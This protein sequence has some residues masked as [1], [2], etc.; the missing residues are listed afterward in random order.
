[1]RCSISQLCGAPPS[2]R[3]NPYNIV[4]A[5]LGDA[6]ERPVALG[7]IDRGMLPDPIVAAAH[8]VPAPSLVESPLDWRRVRAAFVTV[9]RHAGRQGDSL[10]SEDE[11]IDGLAALDLSQPCNVSSDW[12]NG[13]LKKIESE[14]A[15]FE[16]VRDKNSGPVKCIQLADVMKR[17]QRL[18]RLLLKR[19]ESK[20]E[21]LGEDWANLLRE[22]I[23]EQGVKVDF[24]EK[25]YAD[26]LSEQS[27]MLETITTR[28]L[29]VLVGGAGTGKTTVLGALKKS[30]VLSTQGILFLA[31]TG[32]ARVRLGQKTGESSMTVAQFLCQRDRYDA[33]RQRPLFEGDPPYAKEKTV[34]IDECSMLTM[35]DL[36]AV[37]LG[38]V[39]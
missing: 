33:L 32:K 30:K 12:I 26:A 7:M 15:R 5:D 14:I 25:R 38:L 17:E 11:A 39:R 24:K 2:V 3:R 27:R 9:L 36:L 19:A 1:M 23:G 22:S 31:P 10:L 29:S 20:L 16:L 4:E 35:D 37:L 13:N 8:P 28:K 18:S 34:V 21:S 6:D